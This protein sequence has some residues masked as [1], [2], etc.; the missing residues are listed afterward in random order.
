MHT[1]K[2]IHSPASTSQTYVEQ[3]TKSKLFCIYTGILMARWK[4]NA[5]PHKQAHTVWV[6][7]YISVRSYCMDAT[8]KLKPWNLQ[9]LKAC[10]VCIGV[11]VYYIE[12]MFE[13]IAIA[14]GIIRNINVTDISNLWR[15]YR[16]FLLFIQ[17]WSFFSHF[18]LF[19]LVWVSFCFVSFYLWWFDDMHWFCNKMKA[20]KRLK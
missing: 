14:N 5:Q 1:A 10:C 15:I 2:F 9:Y 7:V 3:K 17:V 11:W 6:W 13:T 19:D 12:W 18:L 4:Q 8:G 20:Q 16:V